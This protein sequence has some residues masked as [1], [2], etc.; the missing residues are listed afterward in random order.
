MG[1]RHQQNPGKDFVKKKR[2][3]GKGKGAADNVTNTAFVSRRI[4]IP[5]QSVVKN[6]DEYVQTTKKKL[7]FTVSSYRVYVLM[8][9][10][11][12]CKTS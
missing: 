10:R 8:P 2:K 3:V 6:H 12:S 4:S 5:T 9:T 1:K 11:V 7:S